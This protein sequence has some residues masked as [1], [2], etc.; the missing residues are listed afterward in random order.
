MPHRVAVLAP[1]RI[2][3]HRVV[4]TV[5]V[6]LGEHDDVQVVDDLRDLPGVQAHPA[7]A[8]A[9]A[10]AVGVG[11]QLHE[12]D[13]DVRAAPLAGVHAAQEVDA[14]RGGR[15]VVDPDRAAGPPLPRDV[16]QRDQLGEPRVGGARGHL[17]SRFHLGD[18]EVPHRASRSLSGEPVPRSDIPEALLR[19]LVEV[20]VPLHPVPR[21][22]QP[23]DRGV[24]A[25]A[26]H[27]K[28]CRF[29]LE[30]LPV[31]P[32]TVHAHDVGHRS[33]VGP[34]HRDVEVG[35]DVLRSRRPT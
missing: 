16:R 23:A 3:G 10:G 17:Q 6:G 5:R 29:R 21:F 4:A 14:G 18:V 13:Q 22:G 33:P 25:H 32:H 28:T 9:G 7:L 1:H 2:D 11:E 26:V 20:L 19:G 12:V 31:H 8:D 24:V 35:H 30:R 34:V 27:L 15:A